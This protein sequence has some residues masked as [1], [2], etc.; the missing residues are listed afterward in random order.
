MWSPCRERRR[1][2]PLHAGASTQATIET[3]GFPG[4]EGRAFVRS[5][6]DSPRACRAL[7]R[8][9]LAR[10]LRGETF[11]LRARRDR[12]VMAESAR[13]W[14]RSIRAALRR[15]ARREHSSAHRAFSRTIER[16]THRHRHQRRPDDGRD[17]VHRVPCPAPGR[18]RRSSSR[19]PWWVETAERTLRARNRGG[20]SDGCRRGRTLHGRPDRPDDGVLARDRS[21]DRGTG[22][23]TDVGV[24]AGRNAAAPARWAARGRT[25]AARWILGGH[26][27]LENSSSTRAD[28]RA[29]RS[30]SWAS[31]HS[32]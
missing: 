32:S 31:R 9:D 20:R 4:F 16:R 23:R 8:N 2:G 1:A 11:G 6:H 10:V 21:G 24:R 30:R 25:P 3:K 14:S 28:G 27:F 15:P 29:A 13:V 12:R 17:R 26:R 19:I 18:S 7:A 22:R 5:S